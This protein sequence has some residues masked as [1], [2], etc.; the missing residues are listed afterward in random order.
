MRGNQYDSR[1][2]YNKSLRV[3]EKYNRSPRTS[4]GKVVASS[5]KRLDVI[6]QVQA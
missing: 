4:V 1:D 6:E 5:S 3:A 2:C